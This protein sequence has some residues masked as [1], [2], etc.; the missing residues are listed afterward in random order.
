MIYTSLMSSTM[1]GFGLLLVKKPP[2][3]INSFFGYRTSM[4]GKNNETWDFA[5]KYAGK[6]WLLSGVLNLLLFA[7]LIFLLNGT[8]NFKNVCTIII[9]AQLFVLL[10]VILPTELAL[11]KNFDKDGNRR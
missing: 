4:S 7:T 3:G 11:R 10:L 8:P 5:Q 9:Y 2:Q 6:V 1:I